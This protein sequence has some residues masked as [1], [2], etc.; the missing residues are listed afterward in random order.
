[1]PRFVIIAV[2]IIHIDRDRGMMRPS[3]GPKNAF[4]EPWTTKSTAVYHYIY[5]THTHRL[6][7]RSS[8]VYNIP[9]YVYSCIVD[10]FRLAINYA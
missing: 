8:A 3:E 1:M 2:I 7:L 4:P 9:T 6:H 5:S 10:V